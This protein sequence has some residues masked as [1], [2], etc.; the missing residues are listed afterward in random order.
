MNEPPSADA[1]PIAA[2]P[3]RAAA[4][5]E[6][7]ALHE[8]GHAV[9]AVAL[10]FDLG[11]VSLSIGDA[12]LIAG[13]LV[14]LPLG[15]I[16]WWPEGEVV[17]N[18]SAVRPTNGNA[19]QCRRAA[20]VALAGREASRRAYPDVE[21]QWKGHEAVDRSMA[22]QHIGYRFPGPVE[23]IRALNGDASAKAKAHEAAEETLAP[24][25]EAARQLLAEPANARALTG[26]TAFLIQRLSV[27]SVPVP[28]GEPA[29]VFAADV[30]GDDARQVILAAGVTPQ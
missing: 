3:L 25:S 23:V 6:Q 15:D 21:G 18:A 10:G 8:A 7:L 9:A 24:L 16:I 12:R 28:D 26:L 27:T 5:A 19:E 17:S 14:T 11:T 22:L 20:V 13:E 29:L 2:L 4:T 30:S 1:Q